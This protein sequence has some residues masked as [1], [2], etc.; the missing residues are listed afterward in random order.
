MDSGRNPQVIYQLAKIFMV[1]KI[2]VFQQNRQ[3]KA[4]LADSPFRP[5]ADAGQTSLVFCIP[6]NRA[7][8]SGM[9]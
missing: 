8:Q 6:E 5:K 9:E 2:W 3:P 4:D 1:T 7:G